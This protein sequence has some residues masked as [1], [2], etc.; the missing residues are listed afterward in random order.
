MTKDIKTQKRISYLLLTC[1]IFLASVVGF[2]SVKGLA[3][4][5]AGAG[6]A[7]ILLGAGIELS[8]LV[9]ASFL[10]RYW[11]KL[12]FGYKV[13][14]LIFL[15]L[16]IFVTS[17]GV[18]GILSQAY[19]ENK[20]K[21]MASKSEVALVEEKKKFFTDKKNDLQNE[22]KQI[23]SDIAQTR[24]QRNTTSSGMMSDSKDVYTDSRGRTS[25][26]SNASTRKDYLQQVE[27]LNSDI[28]KM[29]SRRDGVYV[30]ITNISDSIFYYET[31]I[32]AIKSS[33]DVAVELGPLI[34]LSEV[35]NTSL[36]KVLFWFLMVIVF[37]A[38][39][40]AIALLTAYHFTQKVIL[41]EDEKDSD[42]IEE[43]PIPETPKERS[44]LAEFY[45]DDLTEE[46][47]KYIED[48]NEKVK[49]TSS[50]GEF[51]SSFREP[52]VGSIVPTNPN[53]LQGDF[54]WSMALPKPKRRG[55]PT[56]SKNKV[57]KNSIESINE[58]TDMTIVKGSFNEV[59]E[60]SDAALAEQV[61]LQEVVTG[62]FDNFVQEESKLPDSIRKAMMEAPIV[63]P[64]EYDEILMVVGDNPTEQS[65]IDELNKKS[66]LI[67]ENESDMVED[68]TFE[69]ID[70]DYNISSGEPE[71]EIVEPAP[72]NKTKSR[73]YREPKADV[74]KKLSNRN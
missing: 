40:L 10:H 55:R 9:I 32:I 64:K 35:T 17:S 45:S 21:L 70:E 61:R 24:L 49:F 13:G 29:E 5:F 34:Y 12:T 33:N 11:H 53:N 60:Y 59:F 6:M 7:I 30:D 42:N 43:N 51:T 19:T 2:F 16:V 25:S 28:G 52:L 56:G 72:K 46:D 8:K 14:G 63:N 39:P 71:E 44:P 47:I 38:D 18:Y 67:E 62:S 4:V 68:I 23:I 66:E 58:F 65:N 41:E 1:A 69:A 74:K 31:K 57:K 50:F 48:F 27:G 36:D 37:L 73:N 20:N 3:Q 26:R 22:Y 54:S 15:F